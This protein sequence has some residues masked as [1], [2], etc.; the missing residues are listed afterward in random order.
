M[1]RASKKGSLSEV[2]KAFNAIMGGASLSESTDQPVLA[3]IDECL[4]IACASDRVEIVR[5][6]VAFGADPTAP[7]GHEALPGVLHAASVGDSLD[8]CRAAHLRGA[9]THTHTH[10]HTH[11]RARAHTHTHTR[12]HTHTHT[13]SHPHVDFRVLRSTC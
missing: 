3:L 11:A 13:P 12:T 4:A 2:R 5:Y 9:H 6:L 10:T 1:P 7:M 8:S